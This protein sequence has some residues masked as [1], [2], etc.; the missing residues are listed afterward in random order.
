MNQ[1]NNTIVFPE[2]SPASFASEV[3]RQHFAIRDFIADPRDLRL[4]T[5]SAGSMLTLRGTES[6]SGQELT[7]PVN[8]LAHSQLATHLDI[9]ATYYKRMQ[10]EQHG[11]LDASVNTWLDS[12]GKARMVRTLDGRVRAILSDRYR[13]IDNY[14]LANV[15]IPI[16]LGMGAT[17]RRLQVSEAQMVIQAVFQERKADVRLGD[18]VMLGVTISNSEVGQGAASVQPMSLRLVCMNG[19]THNDLGHKRTHLG[20]RLEGDGPTELFKDDTLKASDEALMLQFRDVITNAGSEL[21]LGNIVAEMQRATGVPISVNPTVAVR[22]LAAKRQLSE[23]EE[24]G[25]LQH[26]IQGGE[27]TQWGLVNA[28]TRQAQD[29]TDPDRSV[30]TERLGGDILALAASEFAALV[31]GPGKP[32]RATRA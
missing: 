27:L 31:S 11:L 24:L 22:E 14:D 19:M 25:I 30:D 13:R 9:P 7:F 17:F 29:I 15:A 18:T 5:D 8:P 20:T 2:V 26:L 1:Q 10:T 16:L 23:S 3:A 12:S 28:I 4:Y 6:E 32:R 21:V